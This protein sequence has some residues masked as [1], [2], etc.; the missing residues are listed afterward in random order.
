MSSLDTEF[1]RR[2]SR[3]LAEVEAQKLDQMRGGALDYDQYKQNSGYL[4]A[5]SNIAEW[6][7]QIEQDIAEGK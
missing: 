7:K 2:L 4:M 1:N 5:L 3:K 6:C